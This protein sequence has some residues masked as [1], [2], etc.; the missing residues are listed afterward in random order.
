M[1]QASFLVMFYILCLI[2]LGG[3][4]TPVSSMPTWAQT[5]AAVNPFNYLTKTFRIE[6]YGM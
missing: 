4:I 5:I 1:Q 3:M 2:L 6:D